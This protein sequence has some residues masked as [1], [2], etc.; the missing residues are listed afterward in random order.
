MNITAIISAYKRVSDTI[1]TID[2][3]KGCN[4][5]PDE[6]IVH[7]DN[8]YWPMHDAIKTYHPDVKLLISDSNIGPGGGRNKL[9]EAASYEYVASFDDDSYPIDIYYF[10]RINEIYKRFPDANIVAC[11]IF[12]PNESILPDTQKFLWTKNFV[13]CG[14]IYK[15]TTFLKTA[16]YVPLPWAYGMEEEDLALRYFS[17]GH[18][19]LKTSWLRVFHDTDLRPKHANPEITAAS[20][21]NI[22]LRTYLRYPIWLWWLGGLEYLN[23]ILWLIQNKRIDGILSG[24]MNTPRHIFAYKKYRSLAR[25]NDII[26]YKKYND[27]DTEI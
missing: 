1:K 2:K 3:I 17:C 11:A 6:I 21:K 26:R 19:I 25:T 5:P 27:K 15:K 22:A 16:G 23:R 9:I 13:G 20:I 24:I 8:A 12:H 4:P 10:S 7:I 14:C 18:K